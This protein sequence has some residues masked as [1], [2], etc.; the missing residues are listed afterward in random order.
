MKHL[1]RVI[2]MLILAA[3]VARADAQSFSAIYVFGD[4]FCDTGNIWLATGGSAPPAPYY[5]GR[6]SN[7][8]LWVEQFAATLQLPV[9]PFLVGGTN[10]AFGGSQLLQNSYI[11]SVPLELEFYFYLHGGQADPNAL[12][13]LEGGIN[14]VLLAQNISAAQLGQN[15]ATAIG[16]LELQLSGAGARHFLI[17]NLPDVGLIPIA[18]PNAAF[19]SAASVSADSALQQIIANEQYLEG[20]QINLLDF[21]AVTEGVVS[22]PLHDGFSNIL[23]PCLAADGTICDDPAHTFFWD[24]VHPTTAA[25]GLIAAAAEASIEP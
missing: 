17:V 22:D 21:Y 1:L 4:S 20:I 14:D 12:Y 23:T 6:Y 18:L 25:Q 24:A 16:A 19:A 10:Y 11:P 13:I 3:S 5:E 15:I 9:T 8:P 2:A 7:G